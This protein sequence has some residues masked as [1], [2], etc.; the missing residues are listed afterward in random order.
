MIAI[1]AIWI[2]CDTEVYDAE[3]MMDADLQWVIGENYFC[4][5]F[6]LEIIVRFGAYEKKRSCTREA[7]FVFDGFLVAA[8]FLSLIHI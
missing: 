2:G 8:M 4:F 1:N 5:Y 7:W 6:T 3:G